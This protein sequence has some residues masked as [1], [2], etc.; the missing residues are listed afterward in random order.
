MY[1]F[2]NPKAVFCCFLAVYYEPIE[3][4]DLTVLAIEMTPEITEREGAVSQII[5]DLK[6]T[7]KLKAMTVGKTINSVKFITYDLYQYYKKRA[8][9]RK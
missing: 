5:Q 2:K 6:M 7:M 1:R 9:G 3:K 4:E 8:D